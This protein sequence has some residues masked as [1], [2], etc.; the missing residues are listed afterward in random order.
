MTMNFAAI[1]IGSNAVRMIV[2]EL[3]DSFEL[4]ILERWSAHLRLAI[5]F[6]RTE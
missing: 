2:G 4:R 3:I 6:L 5:Q 1:E